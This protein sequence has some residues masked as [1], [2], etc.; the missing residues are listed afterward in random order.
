MSDEDASCTYLR[1]FLCCLQLYSTDTGV[2]K[3]TGTQDLC[4]KGVY[5]K[6]IYSG[7]AFT[8]TDNCFDGAYIETTSIGDANT[9]D[10]CINITGAIKYL[11][12][13]LQSF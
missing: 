3:N 7:D 4:I 2:A 9:G 1:C 5:T 13:D 10:A 12:T 11:E 8:R 6:G